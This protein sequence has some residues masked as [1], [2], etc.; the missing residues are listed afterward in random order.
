MR[1]LAPLV[2][3]TLLLPSVQG[4]AQGGGCGGAD[5]WISGGSCSSRN[6]GSSIQISGERDRSSLVRERGSHE[7]STQPPSR[8]LTPRP[9]EDPDVV[10]PGGLSSEEWFERC[11]YD[12]LCR[13]TVPEPE[14]ADEDEPAGVD[15]RTATIEDVAEYAPSVPDVIAEPGGMGVVGMPTNFV[16]DIGPQEVAGEIFD[17]PVT[18]R[19]TPVSYL[20]HYGDGATQ[21]SSSPGTSWTDLAAAQ[22]TA[23]PTSHAYSSPGEFD[24]YVDVRYT[25]AASAG[26]GWFPVPGTLT[27]PT[28]VT[29]VRIVEVETALVERTCTEDPDGPGC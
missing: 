6:T 26:T 13:G 7:P 3:A 27:L 24:A 23:T 8:K 16:L 25:A 17:V 10:Y 22:F 29:T 12:S 2:I 20:F 5:S 11:P 28:D 4:D 14:E 19:F 9:V 21:E 1:L 15:I 18:V